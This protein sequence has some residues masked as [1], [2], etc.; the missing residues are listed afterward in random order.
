MYIGVERILTRQP[1]RSLGWGR[2]SEDEDKDNTQSQWSR[3]GIV[4]I[5]YAL[6]HA[7][8]CYWMWDPATKG[9]HES[10]DVIWLNHMLY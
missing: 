2:N 1:P 5:G 4:M 3:R 9:V 8:D 7:G 6:D 10:R